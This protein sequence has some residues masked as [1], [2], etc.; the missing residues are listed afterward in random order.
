MGHYPVFEAMS[1]IVKRFAPLADRV[2]VQKL[3]AEVKTVSGILLP[4]SATKPTNH[5]KVL[6]AGP[7][8]LSKEGHLIPMSVK[9]G[10]TV[11]VPEYGGVTLKLDDEE[12]HV[13]RDEEFMGTI[14]DE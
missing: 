3:K 7:G 11:V 10:D 5:A 14:Q 9:P 4:E 1:G 13:F 6:A 8:R 12:F 2:L